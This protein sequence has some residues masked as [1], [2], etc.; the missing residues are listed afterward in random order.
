ME[1][2]WKRLKDGWQAYTTEGVDN[3]P[4][5]GPHVYAISLY[6]YMRHHEHQSSKLVTIAVALPSNTVCYHVP[7][8]SIPKIKP[9]TSVINDLVRRVIPNSRNL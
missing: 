5:A 7:N 9:T 3:I 1:V 6:L 4:L 2:L 8:A